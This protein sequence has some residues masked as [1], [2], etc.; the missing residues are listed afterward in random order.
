M[1]LINWKLSFRNI[2]KHKSLSLINILGLA[3]GLAASLLIMMYVSHEYNYDRNWKN[4]D[5]IYRISY[6]HYQNSEL[7]FKSAKSL[8]GMAS[9]IREKVPEVVGSTS[10]FKD[11]VT[12]YNENNQIQDIQMFV[13]DSTFFSVFKLDFISQKGIT[14]LTDLYSAV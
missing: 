12:V 3:L 13:A 6:N 9:V 11:V 2:L 5:N 8:N 10:I 1:N 14:P 7:T 4:A